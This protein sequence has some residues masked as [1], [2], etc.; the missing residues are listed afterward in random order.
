MNITIKT[1]CIIIFLLQFPYFGKFCVN[2]FRQYYPY[3]LKKFPRNFLKIWKFRNEI[4]YAVGLKKGGMKTKQLLNLFNNKEV[5]RCKILAMSALIQCYVLRLGVQ[6]YELN[7]RALCRKRK[8]RLFLK[9][10]ERSW[11]TG[12]HSCS[13]SIRR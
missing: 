8:I 10:K 5:V 1:Y 7:S 2:F 12:Y 9:A 13:S 6:A 4:Y 3:C 11:N